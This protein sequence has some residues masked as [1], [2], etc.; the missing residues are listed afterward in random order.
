M[1]CKWIF[2]SHFIQKYLHLNSLDE[3]QKDIFKLL[4]N[5]KFNTLELINIDLNSENVIFVNNI[6]FKNKIET[7]IFNNI[8]GLK[9]SLLSEIYIGCGGGGV[10]R[11]GHA[12]HCSSRAG[13]RCVRSLPPCLG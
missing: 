10:W 5:I 6:I 1:F 2:K 8:K 7:L 9:Y 11:G 3:I 12:S 13:E 4:V